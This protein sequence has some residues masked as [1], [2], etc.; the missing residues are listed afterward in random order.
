MDIRRDSGF[1]ALGLS[2]IG[3]V[4]DMDMIMSR[5]D[6]PNWIGEWTRYVLH[7]PLPFT[8]LLVCVALFLFWLNEGKAEFPQADVKDWENQDKF[9]IWQ[10]GCLWKGIQPCNEVVF[11]NPAYAK[12]AMLLTAA[13]H[14]EIKVIPDGVRGNS[15]SQVTREELVKFAR[16]KG[17]TPDFLFGRPL[18]RQ[19]THWTYFPG[20][21]AVLLILAL[22]ALAGIAN[23]AATGRLSET[24]CEKLGRALSTR[25][26]TFDV[27][28]LPVKNSDS[29]ALD[30]A[31]FY[32][33]LIK[34]N[35]RYK[36]FE[37]NDV[38][39]ETYG[40]QVFTA[41]DDDFYSNANALFLER[42][43]I[44]VGLKPALGSQQ[45][46]PTGEVGIVFGRSK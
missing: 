2:V 34:Y 39:A 11:K 41:A 20:V 14:G 35:W 27:W 42:A 9:Y 32:R 29:A 36:L 24:T 37:N 5:I 18:I 38:I 7:M 15:H 17:E 33:C 22:L 10:A 30:A 28:L 4:G 45:R 31:S 13:Q 46:F 16:L 23:S 44:E 26:N 6:D 19:I 21:V 1:F 40:L 43:L 8:F 12:F 25:Q 3:R